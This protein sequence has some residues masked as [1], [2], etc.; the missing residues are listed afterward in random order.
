MPLKAKTASNKL[1]GSTIRGGSVPGWSDAQNNV[2]RQLMMYYLG[3]G[4]SKAGASA[5]IGNQMQESG[6]NPAEPGGKLSQW[7]GSRLAALQSFASQSGLDINSVEAQAKFT[8]HEMKT[9][10]SSLDT[11]LRTT[12][13]PAAAALRISNEYERPAAWAANNAARQSYATKAYIGIT[14]ASGI[15]PDGSGQGSG[16]SGSGGSSPSSILDLLFSPVETLGGWLASIAVT[17][18][19]DTAEGIADVIIIPAFHWQQ[20]SIISYQQAMFQSGNENML[21]WTATFWGL[22]YWLLFTDPTSGHLKLAPVRNS[23]LARHTRFAQGIPA[24]NQLVKP[25][26]VKAKTPRKPKPITSRA[27]VA[28]TGTM[29]A[30]RHQTVKVTGTHARTTEPSETGSEARIK[31]RPLP[32]AP[33]RDRTDTATREPNA[34]HRT[35]DRSRTNRGRNPN[36]DSGPGGV[37]GGNS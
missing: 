13:D 22:G 16:A 1:K 20:R 15:T 2:A 3:G 9:S 14:G 23:R 19:K 29:E 21:L 10:Y 31:T 25:K 27:V 37:H 8:L 35:G 7:L 32:T 17:L 18:V 24:R 26:D 5:M 28:Q 11:F 6:L 36:R 30:T 12:N 34:D 4:W 33:T